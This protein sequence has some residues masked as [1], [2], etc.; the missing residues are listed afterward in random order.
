MHLYKRI[1]QYFLERLPTMWNTHFIWMVLICL[2][3]HVLYFGLGYTLLNIEVLKE[4]D[5]KYLFF[6]GAHFS[7]YFI[8]GIL[9]LIYFGFRYFTHNPFK[10]F[11]PISKGYFWKILGQ[12]FIIFFLY[13]AVFISFENGMKLK[14]NKL[15]PIDIVETEANKI[16]LAKPFLYNQIADYFIKQRS[17]PKPFPCDDVENFVIGYDSINGV[18]IKHNINFKKPYLSLSGAY[19]QLGKISQKKIDSCTTNDVLDTIYDLSKIYG[20]AEYSLFN[21]SKNGLDN[22]GKY[23]RGNYVPDNDLYIDVIKIHQWQINKDSVAIATTIQTLKNICKK[24]NIN[25]Q[26]SPMKMASAGLKQ[27]LD[28]Q[29][30]IR[31]GFED[32]KKYNKNNTNYNDS[33][34][35]V[36]VAVVDEED[37]NNTTPRQ[38][39]FNYFVDLPK[40]NTLYDNVQTLQTDMGTKQLYSSAYWV[41]IFG[42]LAFALFFVIIKYVALKDLIIGIFISGILLSI[43]AILIA[44]ID[45]NISNDR[46]MVYIGMAIFYAAIIMLIGLLSIFSHAVKKQFV[47]KG[48]ISFSIATVA[49]FPFLLYY[50]HQ[51]CYNEV[52]RLCDI[53]P[54]KIYAFD[55]TPWQF[56]AFAL[57][58]IFIIFAVLRKVYAKVE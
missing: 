15:V 23:Y 40:F 14:A 22:G 7:F 8:I 9:A 26:L 16:A 44:S 18:A 20:L 3:T 43:L 32:Y 30:L 57:L 49:I 2:L 12:L 50:I 51:K 17:Y 33:G 55:L 54:T 39:A 47:T 52:V 58:S 46:E 21:Y 48:F 13:A 31:T 6:K 42:A 28:T 35:D 36:A 25:E 41:L 34:A 45:R 1:N 5:A 19:Y 53:E 37:D 29:Q 11:Y 56:V 10:N 4:Y 24:Y 27:N 38:I